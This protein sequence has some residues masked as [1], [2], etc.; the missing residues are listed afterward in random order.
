MVNVGGVSQLESDPQNSCATSRRSQEYLSFMSVLRMV[1]DEYSFEGLLDTFTIQSQTEMVGFGV[2][3][4]L[5]YV[6]FFFFIFI[7]YSE[8]HFYIHRHL[9]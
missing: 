8:S 9:T 3:F 7:Q 4:C 2:L 6:G 5:L 1:F